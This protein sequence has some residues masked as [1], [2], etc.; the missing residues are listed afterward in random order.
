MSWLMWRKMEQRR[1]VREIAMNSQLFKFSKDLIYSIGK[2]T[3]IHNYLFVK[4]HYINIYTCHKKLSSLWYL[5]LSHNSVT[6]HISQRRSIPHVIRK[7]NS[8]WY[9]NLFYNSLTCHI[10]Q[11]LANMS[12]F[13]QLDPSSNQF[14]GEILWQLTRLIFFFTMLNLLNDNLVGYRK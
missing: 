5:K 9:L 3:N 7:L 1:C 8:I 12:V 11:I 4:Q 10:S 2:N 13:K 14:G 6:G